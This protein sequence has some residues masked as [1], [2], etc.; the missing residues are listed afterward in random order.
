MRS[1]S[2]WRKKVQSRTRLH[3]HAPPPVR[4]SSGTAQRGAEGRDHGL[5]RAYGPIWICRR[6]PRLLPM[7]LPGSESK[8]NAGEC[9]KFACPPTL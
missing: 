5:S 2:D 7:D 9:E 1:D 3:T 6:G 8:E 4:S